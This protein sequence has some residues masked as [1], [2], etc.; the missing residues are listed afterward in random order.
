M[1]YTGGNFMQE[2]IVMRSAESHKGDYGRVLVF[3]GSPGMAGAA[4]MCGRAALNSGAGLVQ[5]LLPSL[6]DPIYPILQILVPEATCIA[7]EPGMDFSRYDVIAAGSGLGS[8]PKRKEILS[9]IIEVYAGILVLDADALNIV[10]AN[11][12]LISLVHDSKAQVILTPHAGEAR[13]LSGRGEGELYSVK[14]PLAREDIVK[15]LVEKYNCIIVFKGHNTIV[16]YALED[17]YIEMFQNT[18]GNP[19][20]ATGGSGDVLTGVIAG[21]AGQKYSAPDA[22]R[23]GV[24]I[25]GLAGDMAAKDKGEMGITAM[26][27]AE[28][29]PYALKAYYR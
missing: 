18:S 6:E 3:A 25:Q 24:Y 12:H 27:I 23:M 22:A 17:G 9:N 7:Y 26:D 15:G 8:D 28:N 29:V 21:L 16:S 11:E 10:S 2:T 13:R 4:A 14:H 20:M 19:G 1:K 5:F